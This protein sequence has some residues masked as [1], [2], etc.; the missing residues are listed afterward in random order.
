MPLPFEAR[1]LAAEALPRVVVPSVQIFFVRQGQDGGV[2]CALGLRSSGAYLDEWCTFGG[3][4]DDESSR[5]A[6]HREGEEEAGV[7]FADSDLIFLRKT[8]SS[9]V[10]VKDNVTALYEYPIDVYFVMADKLNKEPSNAS[11]G[12]HSE[13]AWVNINQITVQRVTP[14]M[15]AEHDDG[16]NI[17]FSTVATMLILDKMFKKLASVRR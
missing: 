9:T 12:E 2:E 1:S 16:S 4:I 13:V 5:E 11:P 7:R 8:F 15:R 17:S 14:E 3:S 6:A 10:R